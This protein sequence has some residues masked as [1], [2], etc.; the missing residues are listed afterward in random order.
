ML[1]TVVCSANI[2]AVIGVWW[3][4]E[5]LRHRKHIQLACDYAK[6]LLMIQ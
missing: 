5:S 4:D 2:Y 6:G 3:L 1:L